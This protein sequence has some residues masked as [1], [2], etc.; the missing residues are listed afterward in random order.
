[1][2]ILMLAAAQG[3][4]IEVATSGVD[5]EQAMEALGQLI[6]NGFGEL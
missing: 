1:M 5:A 6:E 3:T 4:Q 2:G